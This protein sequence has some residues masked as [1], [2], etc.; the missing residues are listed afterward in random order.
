MTGGN[1]RCRC[2]PTAIWQCRVS[3]RWAL[4]TVG[5]FFERSQFG[6]G[7]GGGVPGTVSRALPCA[8]LTFASTARTL[9][10]P[11]PGPAPAVAPL[12][13]TASRRRDTQADGPS[14][15]PAAAPLHCGA[16]A[17][18][19][20]PK[21]SPAPPALSL[22]EAR[23]SAPSTRPAATPS[24]RRPRLTAISPGRVFI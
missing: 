23:T 20:A 11:R 22:L 21:L 14:P 19:W 24:P 5:R 2:R 15:L 13:M 16:V 4:R 9:P 17:S 1:V 3:I 10:A 18:A 8:Q 12:Q 7:Q 6:A